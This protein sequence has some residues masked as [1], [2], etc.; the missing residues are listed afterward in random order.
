VQV[1][2]EMLGEPIPDREHLSLAIQALLEVG[3]KFHDRG[4]SV[5]TDEQRLKI[6]GE[7][8]VREFDE[9]TERFRNP[10]IVPA[11]KTVGAY[12]GRWHQLQARQ[13]QAGT[14]TP[15][16]CSNNQTCLVHFTNY[17]GVNAPVES[18]DADKLEGFYSFCLGK[19]AAR[20][21]APG[22]G[23]SVAYARDVFSVTKGFVRWLW[24]CGTIDLPRNVGSKAFKFGNGLKA[25]TT[26]TPAEFKRAVEEAPGKL[27]LG[28]LLMANCGMTQQDI[29]DLQDSEVDWTE[30]R[31]TRKR[32]KTGNCETVPTVCYKLWH[33]TFR[34]LQQY[35]SG[36]ARVLLTENGLPY[37][38]KELKENGKLRKADGFASNFLHLKKRLKL[39]RSLK[40]LRKLGA[41]LLD[42][43]PN[44]G[45][46]V[47]YFLGHSPKTVADK[48]YR[49]P[50][51]AQFDEAV[52]WLGQQLGQS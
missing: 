12:A 44:Y 40:Q 36:S 33:L 27:K 48:N 52:A 49:R 26:W 30:G 18:I 51:Q 19:V 38:R 41:T 1:L 17:S 47:P 23:W 32:S 28:L 35:R 13:V 21:T 37:V 4:E 43:H 50:S 5:L 3:K 45:R 46:Y 15:D 31:I 9:A 6:L 34:L 29:S 2:E 16:R 20:R 14:L 11:Q 25:I 10:A 39:N 42:D 8:R 24:E 22:E 7:A